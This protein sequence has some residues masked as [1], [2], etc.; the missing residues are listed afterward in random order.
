MRLLLE[1][2]YEL[3]C[4][5]GGSDKRLQAPDKIPAREL[6]FS[7]SLTEDINFLK[8]SLMEESFVELQK[9]LEENSLPKGVAILLHGLPGTGKTATAEMIA[10]ATGRSVYHVDIAASKSFWFGE[11]E[12]LFKKIFTD[13]RRMC[14]TEDRKPILL[15]N[16]ADALFSKRRNVDTGGNCAQ[17]ENA[18]QNILLE[19]MET[20]DGILIATTNLTENLDDAFERRFLFKIKF[21]K[22]TTEAK[23]NIWKSK[24]NW[25]TD[26]DCDKLAVKYDLSGGEID[27]I[28]RKSVMENVLTGKQPTLAMLESWCRGENL[29]R[30]GGNAIGFSRN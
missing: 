25:L 30:K 7:E 10:K 6:F 22:P 13:Y 9:R 12:K 19:E 14:E 16:E 11:S 4:G 27:N 24:L 1:E 21:G 2:D 17:T 15:F 8:N 29:E 5:K 18:L 23:K 26:E 3:F 20:L 28:V